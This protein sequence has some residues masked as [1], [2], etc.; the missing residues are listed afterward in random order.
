[1]RAILTHLGELDRP[2]PVPLPRATAWEM[3]DQAV[4][5]DPIHP[6]PEYEFDRTVIPGNPVPASSPVQ[7]IEYRG[8]PSLRRYRPGARD[9]PSCVRHVHRLRASQTAFPRVSTRSGPFRCLAKA[10]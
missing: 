2:P 6:E 1:M 7:V 5:F 9:R 3:F 4:A 10:R 8:P